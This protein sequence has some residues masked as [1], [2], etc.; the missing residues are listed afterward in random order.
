M[1]C[2]MNSGPSVNFDVARFGAGAYPFL[3]LRQPPFSR[4]LIVTP[5]IH[6]TRTILAVRTAPDTGSS[7][8]LAPRGNTTANAVAS[9]KLS[10]AST[11]NR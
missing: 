8:R 2:E 5:A 7:S 10:R 6:Q 4:L 3:P 11:F 9:F 1:N